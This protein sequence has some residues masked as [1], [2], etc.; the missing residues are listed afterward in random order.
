L[1]ILPG[2]DEALGAE[3]EL[4]SPDDDAVNGAAEDI[5]PEG[6]LQLLLN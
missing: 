4:D 1:S 2:L 3:D 6:I 5:P